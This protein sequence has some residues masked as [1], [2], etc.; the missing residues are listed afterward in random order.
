V[1]KTLHLDITDPGIGFPMERQVELFKPFTRIETAKGHLF[2]GVGLGLPI[3][4]HVV[5]LHNGHIQ[6]QSEEDKGSTF[7][8]VLPIEDRLQKS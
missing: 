3:A 1:D 5:E 7:T 4:K 8:I 2:G 6:V